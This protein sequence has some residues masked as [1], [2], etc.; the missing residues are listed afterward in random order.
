MAA[1]LGLEGFRQA[2]RYALGS[3]R[4]QASHELEII[5]DSTG[6]VSEFSSRVGE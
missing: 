3:M 5:R 6:I 2:F 1:A 4:R